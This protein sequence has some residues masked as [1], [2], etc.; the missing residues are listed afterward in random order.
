MNVLRGLAEMMRE[1]GM[2]GG[3]MVFVLRRPRRGRFWS[4]SSLWGR[5]R[6]GVGQV[7]DYHLDHDYQNTQHHKNN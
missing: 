6:C 3:D 5:G 1:S 4:L 2:Y 7:V